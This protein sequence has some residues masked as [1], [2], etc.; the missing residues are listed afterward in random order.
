LFFRSQ[1]FEYEDAISDFVALAGILFGILIVGLDEV[2]GDLITTFFEEELQLPL[3]P[4]NDYGIAF[5]IGH[6]HP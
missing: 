6:R 5:S 1:I 4:F 3:S 2:C